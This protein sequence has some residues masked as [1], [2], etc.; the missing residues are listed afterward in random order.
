MYNIDI[1][2]SNNGI[3]LIFLSVIYV[4]HVIYIPWNPG[5]VK[6]QNGLT[7]SLL[8][9]GWSCYGINSNA[10]FIPEMGESN[11]CVVVSRAVPRK[12]EALCESKFRPR[13]LK[14]QIKMYNVF[15]LQQYNVHVELHHQMHRFKMH[16]FKKEL[17]HW[18]Y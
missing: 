9:Y 1:I 15:S 18:M 7:L 17:H 16:R 11:S 12:S 14:G 13:Y 2:F 8:V 10:S 6:S 4:C 3:W 5:F